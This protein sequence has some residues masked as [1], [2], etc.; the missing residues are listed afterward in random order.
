[1]TKEVFNTPKLPAPKGPYSQAVRAGDFLFISGLL[2]VRPETGGAAGDLRGQAAQVLENLRLLV[3][4]AG[5]SL[6]DVVKT[7]AFL[8]DMNDFPALNEVYSRYF[9]ANP[10]ARSTVQASPPS[11]FLVEIEAIAFLPIRPS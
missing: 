4:E 8:A 10:P 2:G 1:M 7:T 11:G 3:E 6:A 5:G 9:P